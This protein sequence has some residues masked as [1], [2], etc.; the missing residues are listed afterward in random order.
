MISFSQTVFL[1]S[2]FK[3]IEPPPNTYGN[4]EQRLT[5]WNTKV[6]CTSGDCGICLQAYYAGGN[7]H[8]KKIANYNDCIFHQN[9][10]KAL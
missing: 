10:V 5:K 2:R 1:A 7:L 9:V 4:H 6:Q 3:S 8:R